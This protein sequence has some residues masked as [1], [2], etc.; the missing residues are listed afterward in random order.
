LSD[1]GKTSSNR[2]FEDK[3]SEI[4][5]LSFP[6][7][8]RLAMI[9]GWISFIIVL[10]AY[11]FGMKTMMLQLVFIFCICLY[12]SLICFLSSRGILRGRNMRFVLIFPMLT[13]TIFF[14]TANALMPERILYNLT[15]PFSFSYFLVII[16][17][18]LFF[19]HRYSVLTGFIT[20]IGYFVSYLLARDN[21]HLAVSLS[22]EKVELMFSPAAFI[23]KSLMMVF[24]GYLVG[25][26][27]KIARML[28]SR[29][30]DEEQQKHHITNTF[31][32]IVDPRV[33]DLM[34][35]K[36]LETGGETKENT[37]LFA[38]IR[39][40]TTFSQNMRPPELF[41]FMKEYFDLLNAE[42]K[43]EDG[44]I[45][46]YVGDEVM[47][48]FGAPLP[49]ENHAEKA[50]I[51]ALRMQDAILKQNPVWQSRG[52]PS[53]KA[54]AGIHTGQMLVGCI[55]SSERHKYGAL[56]DSVNLASRL[57]SLTKEYGVSIIAS[58][59]TVKQCSG[60]LFTRR[61]DRVIVRGR[62]EEVTIHEVISRS[63]TEQDSQKQDFV[64]TYEKALSSY[65]SGNLTESL[66]LFRQAL[67]LA[68]DDLATMRFIERIEGSSL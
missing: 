9:F 15:G 1:R 12:A 38:D 16:M 52:L 57:Q 48:L 36:K 24:S 60:R 5:T 28:V 2:I 19:N 37:V 27:I 21:L 43:E 42:I 55:G 26:G 13:P 62:T 14:I 51:A 49:L 44:T 46:E 68:P 61:L 54:G 58:E 59:D 25:V 35:G 11:L 18:C 39:G 66:S 22:R 7:G 33:R 47:V 67:A 53:I 30:L 64:R 56:G 17:T 45:M 4:I 65:F 34:I 31:G 8:A 20:G 3:L 6:R 41:D 63:Y 23:A 32:M 40:F 10:A 50:C 29:I